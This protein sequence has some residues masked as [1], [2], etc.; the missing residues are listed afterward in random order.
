MK[1]SEWTFL[2]TVYV[3]K[4]GS[5]GRW[6]RASQ[7]DRVEWACHSERACIVG[8]LIGWHVFDLCSAWLLLAGDLPPTNAA[9][10]HEMYH[11]DNLNSFRRRQLA[12]VQGIGLYAE[13]YFTKSTQKK[14]VFYRFQVSRCQPSSIRARGWLL[15]FTLLV[16]TFAF[17]HNTLAC[18]LA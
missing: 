7:L 16:V 6:E 10:F 15:Y 9:H 11:V 4:T 17:Y 13:I 2:S 5:I 12:L 3:T 18:A 8:T 14:T 1:S